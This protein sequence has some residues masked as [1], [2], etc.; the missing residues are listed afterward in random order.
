MRASRT[1]S[2]SRRSD[3]ENPA[4]VLIDRRTCH[5]RTLAVAAGEKCARASAC[6]T[7]ALD[8]SASQVVPSGGE[9]HSGRRRDHPELVGDS[10]K[11]SFVVALGTL[12]LS[13]GCAS[14]VSK[15]TWP[16]EVTTTPANA[17]VE[18]V[19]ETGTVVQ[20]ATA[21]FTASL[22]SGVGYFDGE[23]Y[24]LRC[25]APGYE[26]KSAILDTTVNG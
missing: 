16:V 23:K 6:S 25:S 4:T 15:S 5:E 10:M 26:P 1:S 2:C 17:E 9:V 11:R 8:S 24:T 13:T 19:S 21:P 3:S 14:I 7:S 22:K 12:A 20:K 18:V